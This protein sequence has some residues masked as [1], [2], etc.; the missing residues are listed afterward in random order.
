MAT[1]QENTGSDKWQTNFCICSPLVDCLFAYCA[2]CYLYGQTQDRMRDPS[3]QTANMNN[4]DCSS[5]A[6]LHCVTGCGFIMVMKQREEIRNRY[7]IK[8]SSC[9]D[10]CATYWCIAC[11]MMQQDNEVK[12][13][14]AA[15]MANNTVTQGYQAPQ[16]MMMPQQQIQQQQPVQYQQQPQHQ[17]IQPV[18]Y[19]QQPAVQMQHEYHEKK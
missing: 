19:Q 5:F 13:R 14:E 4:D 2:P 10:C 12:R 8:G 18:Q 9:G 17:Q 15:R 1:K 16:G 6:C 3:M 7:S 11:T